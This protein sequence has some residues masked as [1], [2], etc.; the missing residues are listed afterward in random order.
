MGCALFFLALV[1]TVLHY[2]GILGMVLGVVALLF[3]NTGRAAEL[4]GGGVGFIAAKYAVGMVCLPIL[5]RCAKKEPD[6]EE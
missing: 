5:R 3:G 1:Q 2:L 6:P 4:V